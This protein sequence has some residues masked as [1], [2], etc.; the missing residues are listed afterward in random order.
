MWRLSCR[1]RLSEG[2]GRPHTRVWKVSEG[3]AGG[4]AKQ[5]REGEVGR[6]RRGKVGKR[7]IGEGVGEGGEG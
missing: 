5:V 1:L 4:E 3:R 6:A 2:P 7:G